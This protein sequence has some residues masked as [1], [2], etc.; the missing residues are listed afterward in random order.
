MLYHTVTLEL[1]QSVQPI[2]LDLEILLD[3]SSL[4]QLLHVQLQNHVP[5]SEH[6]LRSLSVRSQPLELLPDG[7]QLLRERRI[8]RVDLRGGSRVDRTVLLVRAVIDCHR[9]LDRF[10]LR[11]GDGRGVGDGVRRRVLRLERPPT[12]F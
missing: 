10:R 6:L 1:I 8:Q 9:D 4:F 2:D 3:L 5:L 11:L 12:G 7:A